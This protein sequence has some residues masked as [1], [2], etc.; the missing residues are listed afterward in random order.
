[1]KRLVIL[2]LVLGLLTLGCCGAVPSS[3]ST[4]YQ[5]SGQ[6][7]DVLAGYPNLDAEISGCNTNFGVSGETTTV[8]V[9]VSN[10]GSGKAENVVVQYTANDIETGPVS[11]TIGTIPA[12][13]KVTVS[14]YLDTKFG[15]GTTAEVHVN[16][17]DTE[18]IVRYSADCRQM[19]QQ[20]LN[21]LDYLIKSGL[22]PV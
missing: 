6:S 4:Y 21:N 10:T 8:Y 13:K 20:T 12:G 11:Q 16:A 1:M 22:L 14:S 18:S 19:D 3:E 15:V 7:G 2:L 17:K 9:T 5:P